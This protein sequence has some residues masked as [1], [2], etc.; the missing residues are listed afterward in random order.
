LLSLMGQLEF[1][2]AQVWGDVAAVARSDAAYGRRFFATHADSGSVIGSPGTDLIWAG[3]RLLDAWPA[4]ADEN[5]YTRIR[6]SNVETLL[7]GGNLDFAT[8]PQN[9]TR[10]LLPHLRNGREVVLRNLGHTDDFWTYQPAA[11]T[12]LITTYLDSGR[13]DT[14]LY[15]PNH[16]DFTSSVSHGAIAKIVLGVML[17]LGALTVLSLLWLPL[18]VHR[19]AFGRKASATLR[20]LYAVVLGVGGWLA[21]VL[22][23]LTAL[24]TVPLDDEVVA[25]LSIGLP[26]GLTVSFAWLDRRL[27]AGTKVAGFA[28]AM[29]GALVGA[30]LGYNT[31]DGML[32]LLT[33]VAGAVVGANLTLIGL[34]IASDRRERARTADAATVMLEARPSVG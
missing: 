1:P 3:G 17:G 8:P 33:A 21:G 12:R 27:T 25:A 5:Q 19:G 14:S 24:P 28:A 9:A 26:I 4:S 22:I 15:T 6:D 20:S 32:A 16:V 7:I 29:G 2:D 30:W 13:V 31:I 10:R 23:V 11:S 18:R 34:D